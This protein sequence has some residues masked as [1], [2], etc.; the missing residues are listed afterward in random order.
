MPEL[1]ELQAHAERLTASHAGATLERFEPLSFTALKTFAPSPDRAVG[2]TLDRV[3]RR[4]KYLLLSFGGAAPD[5]SPEE[6]AD[7]G[8]GPVTF[9]V[10]LMQG[11]RLRVDDRRSRR[12]RG[13]VARWFFADASAVLLTE[14]GT[15]R[16]AGVWVVEGVPVDGPDGRSVQGAEEPLAGLGP[17]ADVVDR[18]E[19]AALLQ[20][21]SM[22]L[23]G[24]LRDQQVLAGLGRRLANEICHRARLSP[25]AVT[26][27]LDEAEVDRLAEA[28]SGVLADELAA[29]RA[30]DEMRAARE[31]QTAVHGRT[32]GPCPVC[33]DVVR[34]VEFRDYTIEYCP[35]CQTGGRVLADNAYSRLGVA[36]EDQPPRRRR[37]G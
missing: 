18:S 35:A 29:E 23:H 16:R 13:G 30:H 3:A 20:A 25:F 4:G 5:A 33:D 1:P 36:R 21:H 7:G 24:F 2:H 6:G 27:K 10:H 31:R 17:D 9:V 37:R 14:A 22:R 34:S 8:A 28:V 11:G 12:P 32:G 15:E 19:L 26:G